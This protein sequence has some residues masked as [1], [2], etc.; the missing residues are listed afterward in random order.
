M[1]EVFVVDTN[2]FIEAWLR[3]YPMDVFPSWWQ[4]VKELANAEK[5]I[6][7]DKVKEE[8][9]RSQDDLT[10]WCKNNL[11]NSFFKDTSSVAD[12]YAKVV[13]WAYNNNHYH[14]NAQDEFMKSDNADAFLIAY[15]LND[16]HHR[17]LVTYEISQPENKRKIKIPDVCNA[18]E[19]KYINPIELFKEFHIHI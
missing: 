19:I 10:Q 11:P 13:N 14:K 16:M 7:I 18:F 3:H 12:Q 4:K 2:F 5:I 9:N 8:I 1:K 17:I 6:S 15:C